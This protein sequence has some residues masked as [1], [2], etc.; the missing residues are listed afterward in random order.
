MSCERKE[1]C[2]GQIGGFV[3]HSV[4]RR[5]VKQAILVQC[6]YAQRTFVSVKSLVL[7]TDFKL[8][9]STIIK[10]TYSLVGRQYANN[11]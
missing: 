8:L 1:C 5:R 7:Y 6:S 2:D 4:N 11:Y 9:I 10:G 3:L